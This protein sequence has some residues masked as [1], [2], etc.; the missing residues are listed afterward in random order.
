MGTAGAAAR[1]DVPALICLTAL[2]TVSAGALMVLTTFPA[3]RYLDTAGLL[4]PALPVY[5]VLS[6]VAALRRGRPQV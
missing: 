3:S 1:D 2:Y 6:L 5:G 4:L